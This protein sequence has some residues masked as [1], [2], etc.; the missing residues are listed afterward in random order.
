MRALNANNVS[1]DKS[2]K[3]MK[4]H[5]SEDENFKYASFVTRLV[6]LGKQVGV[7]CL[8]PDT[9][10]VWYDII[11]HH[12]LE[13]EK[14]DTSITRA[15]I[16][17]GWELHQGPI[18]TK[19]Q[20]IPGDLSFLEVSIMKDH[21]DLV[22]MTEDERMSYLHEEVEKIIATVPPNHELK[23]RALQAR[24]R[25]IRRRVKNPQVSM[26]MIAREMMVSFDELRQVLLAARGGSDA[27]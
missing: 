17:N 13:L 18:L 22:S 11:D 19:R 20:V 1:G 25:G 4:E 10:N 5:F 26:L 8:V 21:D 24:M 15:M 12:D 2:M 3:L 7:G 23:L 27:R 6:G 9:Q 16:H 14:E